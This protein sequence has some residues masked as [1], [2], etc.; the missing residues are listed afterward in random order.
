MIDDAGWLH[1]GDIG[2]I[3]AQ[4]FLK[5]TDRK[6]DILVT[7]GGKNVAPQNIENL[8]KMS[9]YIEQV[10]VIGDR[11]KFLT[12]VIAP[13]FDALAAWAKEQRIAFRDPKD[14]AKVPEVIEL[15][16]RE[17]D[18]VNEQLAKFEAIKKFV[19][20]DIP[21]TPGNDLLTPTLKVRRKAVN[22]RFAKEI[23]RMYLE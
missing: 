22:A 9:R 23:E 17:V 20:S 14:L 5:I 8:L 1:T 15:I 12:A 13:A 16:Q 4:G 6:K 11:R 21:F 19:L 3:D 7:A 10:N 18:Q 2:E